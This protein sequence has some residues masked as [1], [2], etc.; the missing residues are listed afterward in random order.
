VKPVALLLG[1]LLALSPA[2]TA[3]APDVGPVVEAERAFARAARTDGVNSAFVRYSAPDALVFQPGPVNARQALA[4]RPL[5]AVPLDWWP[6]YAGIAESGDLGFTTGP[7]VAGSGERLGHGWYFT[8]WRRQADGSWRWLLDHGPPT[9]EAA[10]YGRDAGVTALAAGRRSGKGKAFA[11]VEAAEAEL[12]AAL[13]ADARAALP[14]F[15]AA[16]GRLMRAGPQPAVGAA[17]WPALLA[18]GPDRIEAARLGGAASAAGDLAYT[19][20]TARWQKQGRWTGG[21]YVRIW[22]RRAEGWKLVVD[23]MIASPPPPA[24]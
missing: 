9:R 23:T 24:G 11:A 14:R 3:P 5:P 19:Y 18:A 12:A 13:A 17:A 7:F 10:P 1:A 22:Q 21:H 20:G 15:L 4:A 8:V 16:D 2:E 6:V